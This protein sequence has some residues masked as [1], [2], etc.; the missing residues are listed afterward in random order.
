MITYRL[1]VE[2][3]GTEFR[4]F[5][6]QRPE[7]RTV[8]GALEAA[9]APLFHEP[10]KL[11]VAG[12]TDA[13]VHATTQVVSFPAER[14]FPI[15]RLAIALNNTLPNDCSVR[16]AHVIHEG[17]SARHDAQRRI[18][19]YVILNRRTPSA[20][21]RRYTH[22]VWRPIDRERFVRAAEDVI[23]KHDFVS[24]CGVSPQRGGTVRTVRAIELE[25]SGDLLR[26][27]ITGDGFLHRM[28]RITIG[29]LVEIATGQRALDDVPHVLAARDRRAAGYTAPAEGLFLAGVTYPDAAFYR[30]A[31]V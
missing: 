27:R 20:T 22:H 26:I 25:E 17:F 24:F 21:L 15:E 11:S 2:Y 1:V 7:I 18:Y 16:E 3:D 5:Q 28:V 13:G 10:V 19:E 12:R 31:P 23:G 4:G 9:L 8:G 30:R 29:T 6:Y 14:E